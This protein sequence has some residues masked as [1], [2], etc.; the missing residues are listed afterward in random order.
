MA[1]SVVERVS[2]ETSSPSILRT[3][4]RMALRGLVVAG[5]AG[6][7]WLLTGS[8]AHAADGRGTSAPD[9]TGTVAN[10]LTGVGGNGVGEFLDLGSSRPAVPAVGTV[11]PV[12]DAGGA[13]TRVLTPSDATTV[14]HSAVTT[15]TTHQVA[16][17]ARSGRAIGLLDLGAP[18]TGGAVKVDLPQLTPQTAGWR[19]G[20]KPRIWAGT[21]VVRRRRTIAV[22]RSGAPTRPAGADR[23]ATRTV[24][25]SSVSS[26]G[27]PAVQPATVPTQRA[28]H[29]R[30]G[31]RRY[32]GG[33]RDFTRGVY[34]AGP[35]GSRHGPEQ[36]QPEPFQGLPDP[37][38]LPVASSATSV[39]HVSG[40]GAF[41][42]VPAAASGS[43]EAGRQV[44]PAAGVGRLP[45]VA[46]SPTVSPD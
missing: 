32:A 16:D 41:G 40:G 10:L 8:A 15:S 38:L 9:S 1:E 33:D 31:N 36:P 29:H 19:T 20:K 18:L 22:V 27:A 14:V 46:E 26:A 21:T 23:A 35:V 17:G 11:A 39:F 12:L 7:V 3:G 25:A 34:G 37:G 2:R 45:R 5:F 30:H 43:P 6:G 28:H 13:I 4:V 24:V 42:V 44:I